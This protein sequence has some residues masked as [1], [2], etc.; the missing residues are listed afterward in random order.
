MSYTVLARKWRPGSFPEMV[1]Q[2]HVRRALTNALDDNRL[3]HAF[4]FSGTR[5]VGKTTVAR[6]LAKCLNCEKGVSSEPCGDCDN[7]REIDEGRFIDL[8][9]V[10]AASRTKVD[11]TRELLDNVQYRPTRGAFKVYL[12][13]EVHM[14]SKH[15]FNALLKTLEEPPE[16]VKFLLATTDPQKLPVTVL[17][18]CLQFNLKKLPVDLIVERL[19]MI[20]NNEKIDAEDAALPRLA[21]AASGSMRDALSLLDQAIAF[22]G[23]SITDVDVQSM[24]GTID[25][26]DVAGLL[27]SVVA[28]DA[29]AV[30]QRV[31]DMDE[32]A[33][34][35]EAALIEIAALIQRAALAQAVPAA[36]DDSRG[37]REL[38]ARLADS[39]S[40][41]MLQLCYQIALIGRRDLYLAADPRGGFEMVMLRMLAFRP[42][43]AADRAAGDMSPTVKAKDKSAAPARTGASRNA[44]RAGAPPRRTAA[45]SNDEGAVKKSGAR[46]AKTG[47]PPAAAVQDADLAADT[48]AASTD[49]PVATRSDTAA[50]EANAKR[51]KR[52]KAA[53]TTAGGGGAVQQWQEIVGELPVRGAARELASNCALERRVGG[54]WH[55]TLDQRHNHLLTDNLRSRLRAALEKH[56]DE[57]VDL[58]IRAGA[59]PAATPAVLSDQ[60]AEQRLESARDAIDN[61]P[62]VRALKEKFNA[63]VLTDSV[64]PAD[65]SAG[66]NAD[67][68]PSRS[69]KQ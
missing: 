39:A 30:M 5:G 55:L 2:E 6:I 35:Y 69:P 17:S 31:A 63:T 10:D 15:S 64:R 40:A 66:N 59:P 27:E 4:L 68:F 60:A 22:G 9:E 58:R 49:G 7:C 56:L 13:D 1:G 28:G 23:G 29:A 32:H 42:A 16:H 53:A 62:N 14:L 18:R 26:Q 52:Q 51:P 47:R 38:V 67:L 57:K 33:P 21:R 41:E 45:R 48:T 12:I 25:R 46:R 24:L 34:D 20:C 8:I 50:A 44:S 19:A 11:D 61:D 3:H 36:I 43:G 65:D 37:D 54:V